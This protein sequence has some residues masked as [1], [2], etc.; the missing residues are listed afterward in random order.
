MSNGSKTRNA[1]ARQTA[2]R[3]AQMAREARCPH[4]TWRYAPASILPGWRPRRTCAGCGKVQWL[5]A[6]AISE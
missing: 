1:D 5:T 4:I 3:A 6:S 2:S